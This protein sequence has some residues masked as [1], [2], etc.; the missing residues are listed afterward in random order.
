MTA[1]CQ[2]IVTCYDELGM[3]IDEIVAAGH[4]DALAIKA[5]LMQFSPKYKLDI[6]DPVKKADLSFSDEEALAA[7]QTI[8]YAAQFAEDEHLKFRAAQFVL[9]D[10]KGRLDVAKGIKNLNISLNTFMVHLEKANA[11]T[12]KRARPVVELESA[13]V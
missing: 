6:G 4:G 9:Q 1:S 11:I 10:K 7:K 12:Q 8:A 3:S 2:Q 5:V 13:K